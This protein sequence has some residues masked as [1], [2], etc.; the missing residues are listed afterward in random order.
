MASRVSCA[1]D[2]HACCATR[3]G[4]V[5]LK[6]HN[7]AATGNARDAGGESAAKIP[8]TSSSDDHTFHHG[9]L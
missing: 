5:Y 7:K 2:P 9:A 8:S 3:P 1:L 4:Y 6:A